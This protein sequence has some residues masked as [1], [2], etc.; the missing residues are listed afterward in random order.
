MTSPPDPDLDHLSIIEDLDPE[1]SPTGGSARWSHALEVTL[2]LLLLAGV[3][4]WSGFTW[5]RDETNRSN[6]QQAQKAAALHQWDVAFDRYSA[7]KGYKDAGARAAE[8]ARQ[9]RERD[10]QYKLADGLL[11]AGWPAPALQ[12]ARAVQAIQPGYE[13]VD[14]IAEQAEQQVYNDALGGTVVMRNDANPPGLYYRRSNGWVWLQDS[15]KWSMVVASGC[16]DRVIYDVPGLGWDPTHAPLPWPEGSQIAGNLPTLDG[17]RLMAAR[18]PTGKRVSGS[19]A[20]G[21][22]TRFESLSLDPT[23]IN[24]YVC[25][26]AGVWGQRYDM[27]GYYS[28]EAFGSAITAAVPRLDSAGAVWAMGARGQR[29]V[30]AANALPGASS[31]VRQLYIAAPDG[32]SPRLVYTSTHSIIGASLSRDEGYVLAITARPAPSGAASTELTADLVDAEGAK[33]P[34]TVAHSIAEVPFGPDMRNTLTGRLEISGLFLRRGVYKDKLLLAWLD[35]G[36]VKLKIIDPAN[37][38]V[39]LREMSMGQAAR[40]YIA[41]YEAPDGRTLLLKGDASGFSLDGQPDQWPL[42]NLMVVQASPQATGNAAIASATIDSYLPQSGDGTIQRYGRPLFTNGLAL[43]DG[44]LIYDVQRIMGDSQGLLAY[45]LPLAH[46]GDPSDS[47]SQLLDISTPPGS[48]PYIDLTLQRHY[49][50]TMFA[51]TGNTGVLHARLYTR[52]SDLDL[53]LGKGAGPIYTLDDDYTGLL[54]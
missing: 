50:P 35:G 27:D 16:G 43:R 28:Y 9:L 4:S 46:L 15:D 22:L 40:R 11:H 2:G 29:V 30:L 49:G 51:Y 8:A 26:D 44:N 24:S 38:G 12:A 17:R 34:T 45:E 36:M 10:D 53:T 7:A 48:A 6:Y 37:P 47:G 54:Q 33:P 21:D 23:V 1:P 18:L 41:V 42:A 31:T 25:G 5:W 13:S 39:S 52:G 32:T 19:N 14:V 3:I 20:G